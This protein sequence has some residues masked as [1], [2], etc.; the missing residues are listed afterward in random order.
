MENQKQGHGGTF[1]GGW[2]RR[3]LWQAPRCLAAWRGRAQ[4]GSGSGRH[5]GAAVLA[6]SEWHRTTCNAAGTVLV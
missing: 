1:T 6:E 3:N 2:H 5:L 4:H